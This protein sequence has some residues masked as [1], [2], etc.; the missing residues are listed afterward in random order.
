MTYIFDNFYI[1]VF[2]VPMNKRAQNLS[3]VISL[4][5]SFVGVAGLA[6]YLGHQIGSENAY[7]RGFQDGLDS[8]T[9]IDR[10]QQEAQEACDKAKAKAGQALGDYIEGEND[11]SEA[12]LN[13]A[14]AR[15]DHLCADYN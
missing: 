13:A 10:V 2:H 15:A 12:D 3:A 8:Y 9:E 7:Y 4:G 6:A 14:E 11:I 5:L 1:F